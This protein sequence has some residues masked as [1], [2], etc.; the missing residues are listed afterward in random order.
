MLHS[1]YRTEECVLGGTELARAFANGTNEDVEKRVSTSSPEPEDSGMNLSDH[2]ILP[3]LALVTAQ[4]NLYF[5]IYMQL[6][7]KIRGGEPVSTD[8]YVCGK[9]LL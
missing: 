8:S 5:C 9:H 4:A 1:G 3:L 7:F 2:A 6:Q